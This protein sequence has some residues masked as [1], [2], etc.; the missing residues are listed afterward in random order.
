MVAQAEEEVVHIEAPWGSMDRWVEVEREER[1]KE[2]DREQ[3]REQGKEQDKR[4]WG[5]V[6][7]GHM[8]RPVSFSIV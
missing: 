3:D 4:V 7:S 2:Q 6:G 8:K 5:T 1:G